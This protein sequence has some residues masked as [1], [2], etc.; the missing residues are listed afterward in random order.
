MTNTVSYGPIRSIVGLIYQYISVQLLFETGNWA[1]LIVLYLLLLQSIPFHK[2]MN[3]I[4]MQFSNHLWQCVYFV[5]CALI[6]RTFFFL[7]V[8]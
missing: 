6:I 1:S 8:L 3:Y 4:K 7:F 2:L 5:I